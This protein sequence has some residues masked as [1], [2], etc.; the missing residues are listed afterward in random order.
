M[1]VVLKR[2]T[3]QRHHLHHAKNHAHNF[4]PENIGLSVQ[5]WG[6]PQNKKPIAMPAPPVLTIMLLAITLKAAQNKY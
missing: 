3:A 4:V 5:Y 1:P 2:P 6:N